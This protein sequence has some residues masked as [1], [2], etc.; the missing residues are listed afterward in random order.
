MAVN[1][2]LIAQDTAP[3]V[4]FRFPGERL[5]T[6]REAPDSGT[7]STGWKCVLRG[8]WPLLWRGHLFISDRDSWGFWLQHV[9]VRVPAESEEL[10]PERLHVWGEQVAG[11]VFS[12]NVLFPWKTLAVRS[13]QQMWSVDR[14]RRWEG[15][16]NECT[17]LMEKNPRSN[18]LIYAFGDVKRNRLKRFTQ[19][20]LS[21]P[22]L[23]PC[24]MQIF[25][26]RL[27][28]GSDGGWTEVAVG[29]WTP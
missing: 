27:F 29:H 15:T 19:W 3:P 17:L 8:L 1:P 9:A 16:C 25:P 24:F 22:L 10:L 14:Y 13:G 2:D 18:S 26:K 11:M 5:F 12:L 20:A 4:D 7:C 28:P 6:F 21:R 23:P